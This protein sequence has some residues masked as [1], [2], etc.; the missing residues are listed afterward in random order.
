ML[1]NDESSNLYM[2]AK[3]Q[4]RHFE[5]AFN[6]I[7]PQQPPKNGQKTANRLTLNKLYNQLQTL[8]NTDL[9]KIIENVELIQP[10]ALLLSKEKSSTIEFRPQFLSQDSVTEI[11]EIIETIQ[12]K[13]K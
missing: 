1:Y 7:C 13:K 9:G 10:N 5:F 6:E 4:L 12:S 3:S 8:N 2:T 11:L